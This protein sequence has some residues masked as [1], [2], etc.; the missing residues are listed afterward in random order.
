M[1]NLHIH[2]FRPFGQY[3]SYYPYYLPSFYS[4]YYPRQYSRYYEPMNYITINKGPITTE[5]I[6]YTSDYSIF[7]YA[8]FILIFFYVCSKLFKN[9]V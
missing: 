8:L 7:Y 3:F 6:E 5:E 9:N 2:Q 4:N 1:A